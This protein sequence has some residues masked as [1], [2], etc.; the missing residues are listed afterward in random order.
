MKTDIDRLHK[1]IITNDTSR[2]CGKTLLLC[3]SVAGEIEVGDAEEIV[4]LG[5]QKQHAEFIRKV[6]EEVCEEHQLEIEKRKRYR[7]VVEGKNV[8]FMTNTEFRRHCIG[9]HKLR[10]LHS[11]IIRYDYDNPSYDEF[12]EWEDMRKH[13]HRRAL[14]RGEP[15]SDG[16]RLSHKWY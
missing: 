2:R 5:Q 15:K 16:P 11:D 8:F 13:L 10:S 9:N 12:D 14:R 6:F 3:H 1:T 7:L 4:C